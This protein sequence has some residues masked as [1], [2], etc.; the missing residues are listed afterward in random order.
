MYK[1]WPTASLRVVTTSILALALTFSFGLALVPPHAAHASTD[2]CSY[3]NI[4]P[5]PCENAQLGTDPSISN[6]AGGDST[7][8]LGF[9]TDISVNHGGTISFKISTTSKS[10]TIAIFRIGYYQ[11]LGARQVATVTPNSVVKQPA[12]LTVSATGLIDCGNWSVSATWTVP[13]SAVSG[14]YYALLTDNLSNL[15]HIPFIV[16]NDSSTS[17]IVFKTN[18]TTWEAYNDYGGN[19]LYYGNTSSGCG[20]SGQYSCGRAYKVSYN[21]P[22]NLENQGGGYGTSNYVWYAE[23]PMVRWLEANGYNVGYISSIDTERAPALLRNHKVI[24]SAGHD[25]YWSAGERT[26]LQNA[27]S[28]GVNIVSLAGN[29]SFWKTR[30]ESSVDGSNTAYR[31]MVSYKETV[32]NQVEDPLDPPTWTGTWRDPRFSPPADGGRPE[33]ALLGTF[34]AVNRGSAAPVITAPFARLRLWRDTSVASLTGSQTATLGAQTIGYEWDVDSDNGFRPAGLFDAAATSVSV[35]ELLQDYGNTYSP[36]TAIWAPTLYRAAGGGLVFSAGTVQWAWGLDVNHDTDPD[37]GPTTPDVT[38][39][40][41]TVNILADMSA[42]PATIQAG[43]VQTSAS[44]DTTAPTS[45]ITSPAAGATVYAATTVAISGSA[46]DTGGGVVAGIEISVDNGAT[47]HKANLAVAAT[48]VTWSYSWTPT[49]VGVVTIKTRAVDDSANLET[50]SAGVNVTVAPRPCPCTLFSASAVPGTP[51]TGDAAAVELGVKFTADTPGTVSGVKFYKSSSNSGTHTGSLWSASGTLLATGTF[52]NETASGWQTLTFASP[53]VIQ[54]N[55][56]YV[57]SYHTNTGY[58][59]SDAGYFNAR[60]DAPPLHAPSS[61]ASGGNGVFI[62]GSSAFPTQSYSASNYWVDV[63]FS[64]SSGAGLVPQVTNISPAQN[65]TGVT[66]NTTVT[67]QFNENVTG[68]SI[69]FTLTG[70]NNNTVAGTTTYDPNTFTATFTPNAVLTGMITYTATVSGATDA[71]GHV[72]AAP[73]SWSFTTQATSTTPPTVSA[74]V[75]AANTAGVGLNAPVS[76][77]FNEAVTG[78][79]IQFTLTGPNSQA[80]SGAT[81]YNGTSNITTFTPSAPLSAGSR[82]TATISGAASLTGVPMSAPYSWSFTT[83]TCPC[84]LFAANS[85]PANVTASD[86][87]AVELG[88]KFTTDVNGYIAG[89]RFYKGPSNT[90]THLGSLWSAS[91]TLLAQVTFTNETASGWQQAIFSQNVAVTAGTT[92]V[93]SYHTSA[94]FYSYTSSGFANGVDNGDLHAP[95]GGTSG[96][97]GVYAYGATQ[98]PTSTYNATNYWVDVV[99][100]FT[101]VNL[102]PPSVTAVSPTANANGVAVAAPVTATFSQAVT[103]SSIQFTLT[104][105]NSQVVS[106][107]T[108]YNN[109][110]NTATFTPSAALSTTTSYTASVSGATT[111]AGVSMSSPYTWSF[112]TTGPCP[113]SIFSPISVPA[114]ITVQDS[115]SLELGMKFTSDVSGHVTGVRFYKGSS[116]TGTHTGSL[117]TASGTLLAQVTFTNETASGWQ[118]ATFSTAVAITAGTVYVVSYHTTVGFYSANGGY[119]NSAVDNAPLHAVTNGISPNGVYAYGGIQFPSNSYNATNYWVDV[120]FTTT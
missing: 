10:Y 59:S 62:Y 28:A 113:C 20:A 19:S 95:S 102:N 53:V 48:P 1:R 5:I 97:N 49:S 17:D 64:S 27:A 68:S 111:P 58:Y 116:N 81:M 14:I 88:M 42:Q 76:A 26:A 16:R 99:F 90:G 43:L 119:F 7:S 15:S 83:L 101:D 8:V 67:A 60:Y 50:P 77:T 12:C 63:I 25:E 46:T 31:T 89:V 18:D 65:A 56:Q 82:Y 24:L 71:N 103:S 117:W 33:N 4:N 21:R 61:A 30:W 35:P 118:Q 92:Y 40:Q 74:T 29:T 37:T 22:F 94:G 54:A 104:G 73:M 85:V 32:D 78:S 11:G 66:I 52:T 57:V 84:S 112:T 105:P 108:S 47:W 98:F 34:F 75:P 91:G 6:I 36:G 120:V 51:N 87:A 110:T 93:V 9:A 45:T 2:P 3:A 13:Q 80:V 55:T 23:Y 70:P 86:N 109:G 69:Q 39:E 114:S 44:T 38:M 41:A 100:E 79:S 107:T 96:G 72:M 115:S 106:G